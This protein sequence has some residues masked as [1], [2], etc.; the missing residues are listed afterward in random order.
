MKT[1]LVG[2]KINEYNVSND[3]ENSKNEYPN[4]KNLIATYNISKDKD[5]S[6]IV[7]ELIY[8]DVDKNNKYDIYHALD[9]DFQEMENIFLVD[10]NLFVKYMYEIVEV[11]EIIEDNKNE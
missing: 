6:K 10:Y 11:R 3:D 1:K 5:I 7:K 8:E 2:Y 9:Y 4:H